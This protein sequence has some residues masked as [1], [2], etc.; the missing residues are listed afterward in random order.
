MD[1][2]NNTIDDNNELYY[3]NQLGVFTYLQFIF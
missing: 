2:W 1:N 3:Y